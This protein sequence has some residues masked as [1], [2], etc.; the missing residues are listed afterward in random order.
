MIVIAWVQEPLGNFPE[1]L[2]GYELP[3]NCVLLATLGGVMYCLRAIY[4]ERCVRKNWD[5]DWETWYY[6]RPMTSA[7][8]G[9]VAYIFLK[10]GLIVLEAEQSVESGNYGFLALAFIAGFNVS[11]FSQKIEDIA[12][13]T[14]G[15]EKSR[16]S[17]GDE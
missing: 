5:P 7:I 10:A 12:K 9:V 11:N 3:I 4:L 16:S 1:W 6:L 8:S 2:I 14:F 13:S 15:I 17:K